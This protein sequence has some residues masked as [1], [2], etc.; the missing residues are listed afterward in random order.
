MERIYGIEYDADVKG[1]FGL[2]Y[3]KIMWPIM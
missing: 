3:E 1:N 2:I